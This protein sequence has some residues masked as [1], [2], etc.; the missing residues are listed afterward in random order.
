MPVIVFEA[1]QLK[2]ETKSE[3]I[4]RLTDVSVEVTGIPKELFFVS[5]HELPDEDIAVG[6]VSVKEL[7]ERLA[8]PL[9]ND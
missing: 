8:Q 2:K 9:E 7:K 6:G 4:R 5:I 3:L 1:G